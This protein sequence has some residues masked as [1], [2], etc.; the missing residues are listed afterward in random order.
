M[1]RLPLLPRRFAAP[2]LPGRPG[3]VTPVPAVPARG[4]LLGT[5]CLALSACSVVTPYT[6]NIQ[7]GTVLDQGMLARLKPGMT[8]NQVSLTLGTPLLTDP[9]HA[10]RWDYVYYTRIRGE[11]GE[12]RRLRLMFKEDRLATLEGDVTVANATPAPQTSAPGQAPGVPAPAPDVGRPASPDAT[13]G[14]APQGP[15]AARPETEPQ[16]SPGVPVPMPEGARP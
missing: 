5:L 6:L 2:R 14:D 13:P 11:V 12:W 8:R 10:D 9:Y 3:P 7:Q 16:P 1:S 15:A 4:V